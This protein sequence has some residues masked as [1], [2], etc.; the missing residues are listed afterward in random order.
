MTLTTTRKIIHAEVDSRE[1]ALQLLNS[2]SSQFDYWKSSDDVILYE[3]SPSC[4]RVVAVFRYYSECE[5]WT[6]ISSLL[7]VKN[8]LHIFFDK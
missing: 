4:Q 8:S 6:D 5:K 3:N 1:E 2:S 7:A